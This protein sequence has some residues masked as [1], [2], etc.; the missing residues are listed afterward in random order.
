MTLTSDTHA[1]R[2]SKFGERHAVII[3][4]H[5][6]SESFQHLFGHQKGGSLTWSGLKRQP[7]SQFFGVLCY[8]ES[9]QLHVILIRQHYQT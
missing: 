5:I 3:H 4:V 2:D 6:C 7:A 1:N 8:K 9:V